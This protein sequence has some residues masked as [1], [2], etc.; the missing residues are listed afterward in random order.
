MEKRNFFAYGKRRSYKRDRVKSKREDQDQVK[1][2][3]ESEGDAFVARTA[4]KKS[5]D[6]RGSKEFDCKVIEEVVSA[7]REDPYDENLVKL[8]QLVY[9][10]DSFRDGQL[11]AI[12][13]VQVDYAYFA[14]W[15]RKVPVL[16]V[17]CNDFT[18][19]YLGRQSIGSLDD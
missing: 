18:W 2:F 17:T 9:G 16:S 15:R 14:H 19:N 5:R 13:M 4:Q 7:V 1:S 3:L 8:L 12:K 6:S 11:E 10:Y